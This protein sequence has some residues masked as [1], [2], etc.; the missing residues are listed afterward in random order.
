[1]VELV[2]SPLH[3]FERDDRGARRVLVAVGAGQVAVVGDD[4]LGV[5]GPRVE[6][7][8]G[9]RHDEAKIYRH[10]TLILSYPRRGGNQGVLS[11]R[12]LASKMLKLPSFRKTRIFKSSSLLAAEN[13]TL[14][15]SRPRKVRKPGSS[16]L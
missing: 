7:P 3:L 1:L 14:S 6:D 12:P 8:L 11:S 16:P 4:H 9:S 13:W 2:D 10:W 15:T 5:H